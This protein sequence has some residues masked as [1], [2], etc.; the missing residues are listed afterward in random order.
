MALKKSLPWAL[1]LAAA[2]A[3][4]TGGAV[5]KVGTSYQLIEVK[6]KVYREDP[7]PEAQLEQNAPVAAGDL[8]RTG[9][10]SA[11]EIV[12]PEAASRFRI[13]A[14]TRAR[15]ASG[16]PGVLLE[17]EEGRVHAL[18]DVLTGADARERL[19]TTPS[20]VLAVRGTEYGVEVDGKGNT[21]VTVFKGVVDV[22]DVERRGETVRVRAGQYSEIR[23]GKPPRAPERHEVAPGQ[24]ERGVRPGAIDPGARGEGPMP[25]GGEPGGTG[26]GP[27]GGGSSQGS[28]GGGSRGGGRG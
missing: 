16:T 4:N 22:H 5:E 19:V 17:I 1:V 24:W 3:F 10:R 21:T 23:R 9:S 6:R 26:S 14:K 28:G 2:V 27:G 13:G 20:A 15:L 18:F 11:A 12:A 7:A 25:G 8:L